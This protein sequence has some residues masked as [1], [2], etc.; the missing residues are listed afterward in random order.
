M[1]YAFNWLDWLL[2][3]LI[4]ATAVIGFFQGF[5]NGLI[6][7]MTWAVAIILAYFFATTVQVNYYERWFTSQQLAFWLSFISIAAIVWII[8]TLIKRVV[9]M[10]R[11]GN[12]SI[13]DKFF[14]ALLSAVKAI[15]VLSMGLWAIGT[16][17]AVESK[18]G[19]KNSVLVP[20]LLTISDWMDKTLPDDFA[21]IATEQQKTLKEQAETAKENNTGVISAIGPTQ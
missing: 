3:A 2:I 12:V 6:S 1:I 4:F 7:L 10:S 14:G 17:N 13:K 21:R 11:K 20:Y 9:N 8:G 16:S 5:I 19:W 18:E 15:L